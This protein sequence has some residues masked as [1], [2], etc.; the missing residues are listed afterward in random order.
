MKDF[1][2][3]V[4]EMDVPDIVQEKAQSAFAKIQEES[5]MSKRNGDNIRRGF[6]KSQAA[7]AAA[8]VAAV[9]VGGGVVYAAVAHLGILDF[10]KN[11]S[12]EI[13]QE[14]EQYIEK[15]IVPISEGTEN[16][17]FDCSVLEALC[18]SETIMIVYEV[19]A[20][21]SGEYLFIPEDA[22]PSDHMSDWT[23]YSDQVASEYASAND[24]TIVSIGGGISNREELGISAESLRF[25]SIS[26]DV[27]DIYVRCEKESDVSNVQV[28]CTATAS[29]QDATSV[30]D[31]IR[32]T[33]IFSLED[34]TKANVAHYQLGESD[35]EIDIPITDVQ[36][37]QTE[38][39]TYIDVTYDVED[40]WSIDYAL[41]IKNGEKTL[42]T[43]GGG[44]ELRSDGSIGGQYIL[45]RQ[46]LG[47][48]LTFEAFDIEDKGTTLGTITATLE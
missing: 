26:D 15:D 30:D 41:R 1:R 21:E 10:T 39:G 9:L 43:R 11:S 31:I 8:I 12:E 34:K 28:E 35:G 4:K 32:K 17:L 18:D 46:E 25:Q 37:T 47:D 33:L 22:I 14:A 16:D 36:V 48:V 3:L 27:M 23:N 13:P 2:H 40:M 38:L 20:K 45:D 7:A 29:F 24:L 6:F 19:S 44:V 5:R 42:N